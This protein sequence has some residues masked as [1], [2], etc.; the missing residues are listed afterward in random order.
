MESSL[1]CIP[2]G[3]LREGVDPW[4]RCHNALGDEGG[5]FYYAHGRLYCRGAMIVQWTFQ[6]P[7]TQRVMKEFL[8]CCLEGTDIRYFA[9]GE[10]EGR[11]ECLHEDDKEASVFHILFE[12]LSDDTLQRI[13]PM[14]EEFIEL[15]SI[16]KLPS[17]VWD[18][19][20]TEALSCR[21]DIR[22]KQLDE[23]LGM[24]RK[25]W[26]RMRFGDYDI[27]RYQLPLWTWK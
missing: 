20:W 17:L 1:I 6:S 4:C 7:V 9:W 23:R 16:V 14:V 5:E 3:F 25:T 11:R 24:D 27:Y 19:T 21:T 13:N 15:A 18:Q 2:E 22:L 10:G 12:G 8:R 26:T